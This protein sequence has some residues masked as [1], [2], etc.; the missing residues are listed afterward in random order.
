MKELTED[1]VERDH[2][3]GM[4]EARHAHSTKGA[5]NNAKLRI[6]EE[7]EREHPDVKRSLEEM[8]AETSLPDR[9]KDD[10]GP[11]SKK[12]KSRDK[13]REL[14][15][16]GELEYS[17]GSVKKMIKEYTELDVNLIDLYAGDD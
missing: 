4:E 11:E 16:K 7:Q 5:N 9:K 14:L 6:S 10:S 2:Q 15:E 8:I 13:R 3:S 17:Y 1:F 12:Q